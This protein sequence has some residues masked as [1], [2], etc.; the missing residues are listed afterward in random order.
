[1]LGALG[2]GHI[3]IGSISA[4]PSHGNIR[5][6]L[7]RIPADEGIVVHYGVPSDG[8]DVVAARISGKHYAVP[9]GI[10]LVKTNDP[11]RPPTEEEVLSDYAAALA[12]LQGCASYIH[13]NLSCPNSANDRDYFDQVSKIDDLLQ[14]LSDTQPRVPVFVK[15]RPIPDKTFLREVA[16]AVDPY[17]FV[18]GLAVNLPAGK[19]PELRLKTSRVALEKLPGSVSGRPTEY[20]ANTNLRLL[21]EAIGPGS[22]LKLMAA[23]GVFSADDAYRKIRLGASLVQVYTALVYRGPGIAKGILQGLIALLE[24]DGFSNVAEAVGIDVR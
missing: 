1:M 12:K 17:P 18:A 22:R 5:P 20:L 10:N 21:Y 14:R 15:L 7:F 24:R 4:Y 3:E 9:V 11:H 13:L 6:R 8:A 23:G 2:F 16:A 19:P